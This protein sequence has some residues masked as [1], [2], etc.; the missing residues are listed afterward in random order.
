MRSKT[1]DQSHIRL[2]AIDQKH[3]SQNYFEGSNSKLNKI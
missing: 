2:E 3:I 1:I